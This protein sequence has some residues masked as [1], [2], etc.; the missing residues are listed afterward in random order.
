VIPALFLV[1]EITLIIFSLLAALR[2]PPLN[3]KGV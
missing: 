3:I 2:L 1:I